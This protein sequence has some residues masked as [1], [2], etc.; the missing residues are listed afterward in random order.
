V[1]VNKN[2]LVI[3]AGTLLC[4]SFLV[5]QNPCPAGIAYN[6]DS[7]KCCP[8]G[9]V[10]SNPLRQEGTGGCCPPEQDWN[11]DGKNCCKRGSVYSNPTGKLG[12]GGCCAPGAINASTGR[13]GKGICCQKQNYNPVTNTCCPGGQFYSNPSGRSGQGGCCKQGY[14]YND[15]THACVACKKNSYNFTTKICCPGGLENSYN[16]VAKTCCPSGKVF[17][18]VGKEGGCCTEQLPQGSYQQSCSECCFN[19]NTLN[20]Q[21]RAADG[22]MQQASL[23]V[24]GNN[25]IYNIDGVLK[26][27]SGPDYCAA[28]SQGPYNSETNSC[29]PSGC[30]PWGNM[31]VYTSDGAACF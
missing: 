6:P 11:A 13:P 24:S 27:L 9:N 5:G 22:S 12:D 16:P 15:T 7:G 4:S 1:N 18:K 21:C 14:E 30:V 28:T 29:C 8:K 20:C 17:V 23:A 25:Q 26:Q 2:W 10:Y 19:D 31:C 3:A